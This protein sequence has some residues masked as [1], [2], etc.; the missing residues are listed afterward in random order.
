MPYDLKSV[1]DKTAW[2]LGYKTGLL[3]G[4][5]ESAFKNGNGNNNVEVSEIKR[6]QLTGSKQGRKLDTNE[7]EW[8]AV[9][10]ATSRP[11]LGM[12]IAAYHPRTKPSE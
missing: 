6:L 7:N 12:V 1:V 3:L 4:H 2:S 9:R 5:P 11:K 10:T 8:I